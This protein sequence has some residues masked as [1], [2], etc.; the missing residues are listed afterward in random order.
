MSE[1]VSVEM[2][3]KLVVA[4]TAINKKVN[5]LEETLTN[6]KNSKKRVVTTYSMYEKV[7]SLSDSGSDY[8]EI[9]VRLDIPATTVRKYLS[10]TKDEIQEKWNKEHGG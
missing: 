5:V 2:F 6:I 10:W 3:N 4:L 8:K 7:K 1:Y 9:A